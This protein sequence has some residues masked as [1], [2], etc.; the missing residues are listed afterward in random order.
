MKEI[1]ARQESQKKNLCG[2][3]EREPITL[4]IKNKRLDIEFQAI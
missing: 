4:L 2:Q 1:T 3:M